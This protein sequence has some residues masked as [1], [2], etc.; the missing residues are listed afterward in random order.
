MTPPQTSESVIELPRIELITVTE[1]N[2]LIR[3]LRCQYDTDIHLDHSGSWMI[4]F[5]IEGRQYTLATVR[6]AI[7]RWRQLDPV[8][9]FLQAHCGSSREI[10]LHTG[11][12]TLS[13]RNSHNEAPY[14]LNAQGEI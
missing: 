10:R 2:R 9:G 12:W 7:R 4:N 11:P 1:L 13:R 14:I 3:C 8:L 5:A 6:G